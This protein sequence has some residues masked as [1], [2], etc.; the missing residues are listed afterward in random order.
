MAQGI[1]T[2]RSLPRL[3]RHLFNAIRR[4][5]WLQVLVGMFLGVG[6][7]TL[8]GPSSGFVA[9]EYSVLIGNWVA[10]P[11]RLFLLAIQFVVVPLV[12]AS[13]IRGI[14]GGSG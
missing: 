10:L 11:G 9:P 1:Q 4:R 14:A 7:G 3:R 2:Q 5:L 12:V 8:V 6:F 13:V